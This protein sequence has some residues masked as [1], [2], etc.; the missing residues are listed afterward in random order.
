MSKIFP[1]QNDAVVL[2]L[3]LFILFLVFKTSSS[4]NPTFNKFYKIVPSLLLCYFIP[5]ILNSIGIVSSESSKLYFVASRYFLPASLVLLCISI[6]LKGILKLG[7]KAIIMFLAA[8]LG[9]IIGGPVALLLVSKIAPEVLGGEGPEEIWRGLSTVAGSWIGGGANQTAMKEIYGASDKLFSAMIIVDIFVANVFMSVLLY[10]T[11]KS[12]KIDQWLGANN[13]AIVSLREKMDTYQDSISKVPSFVDLATMFGI[14]FFAVGISHFLADMIGPVLDKSISGMI[15]ADPDS[16]AFLLTSFGSKFFWLVVLSTVAGVALSFTKYRE[17]EGVGASKFGSLFLYILVATIGMKMNI[18]ELYENW[19][20]FKYL[21]T[22]GL[23][24]IMIHAIVLIVV[25]KM[26]K[27]PFFYV[28]VGSQAN[29]GGAASA[30]IVASAFSPSLAPVGVLL[31][32][33]GYAVGTF[34]AIICTILLQ[35]VSS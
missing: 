16:Y 1:L 32:V 35:W 13:S 20:V 29:V 15:E 27:A 14:A 18:V 17:L 31:A 6:D 34:G 11:G 9:I 10:C 21:I 19:A 30:P 28:A 22:V 2:G 33:F 24:W 5:A 3:L 26:I 8:S 23:I 25:A 4:K 7:P 12:D